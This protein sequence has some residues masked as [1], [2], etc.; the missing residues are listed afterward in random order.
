MHDQMKII[1]F[2]ASGYRQTNARAEKCTYLSFPDSYLTRY[3]PGDL[4]Y[5]G[6]TGEQG[7]GGG[8]QVQGERWRN[9][10]FPLSESGNGLGLCKTD[11]TY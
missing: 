7:G 9:R 4:F 5:F 3:S 10:Y 8:M 1:K 11:S 6:I 2:V